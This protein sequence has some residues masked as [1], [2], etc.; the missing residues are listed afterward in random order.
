MKKDLQNN[1]VI[2]EE[3]QTV[4][5]EIEM[6]INRPSTHLYPDASEIPLTLNHMVFARMLNYSISSD[7]SINNQVFVEGEIQKL[8]LTPK[9]TFLGPLA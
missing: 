7:Q 5:L 3:M 4:Q 1:E 2:Y 8:S 9:L 6:I